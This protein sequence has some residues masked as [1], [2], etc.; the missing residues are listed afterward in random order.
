MD[1]P[2]GPVS[3]KKRLITLAWDKYSREKTLHIARRVLPIVLAVVVTLGMVLVGTVLGIGIAIYPHL[4]SV[5]AL[6]NTPNEATRIFAAD[7]EVVASLY[8]ENRVSIPLSQVPRGLQRAVIDTEDADFYR[9]RGISVRG[10]LRA[11]FRNLVE[12]SYAE[13]GSTIT[14]QLARNLFLTGEKSIARKIAEMM[15]AIQI[16]RRLTK[17]EILER[18]LN[19]VYFGQGAYGVETA[20]EV[21]FGKP[22]HEL[23]LSESAMLAGLIRAPTAYSPYEH[24]IRARARR[25]EVLERMVAVRDISPKERDAALR[26]P[27]HLAEKGNAGLIGIRA[28]YFVSYL[29]PTLVARY[30]EDVLYKAGLR[31]YTTLDLKLQEQADVAIRQGID[32]ALRGHLEAHQG[33]LVV[34]DPRTG[35]VRA[36]V[37]GYDFRTSQFNRAW[38]AHRQPGSAFK[39]FTYTVAMMQGIPPT[40]QL[41]DAP[42]DVTEPDGTVWAPEN[43]DKKWHGVVS[44]R[45]A[46]E[47][48]INV[49]SIRLEQEVGPQA[50]VDLAHHMGIQSTLQPNLSL[51]LGTADV[52]LL[53]MTSAYG[54]FASGGVRAEPLAILK[55]TDRNGKVLEEHVPQRTVVLNP[56][57]SYMMIDLLKGVIQRGTGVAA[58]IKIPEAG[59]TGTAD[60]FRNAWFIGFT[61]YMVTGVWV[62]N[63]DDSPMNHVPGGSVPANIWASFMKVA[64]ADQPK[65]DWPRPDGIVEQTVCGSTGLLAGPGCTDPHQEIFVKGTEPESYA[66]PGSLTGTPGGPPAVQGD[67][68]AAGGKPPAAPASTADGGAFSLTLTSPTQGSQVTPPFL[69]QGVTRPSVT[70]HVTV[71]SESGI[72]RVQ[73]ADAYLRSDQSG[74]FSYTVNPW[75]KPSGGTLNI[76][77]EAASGTESATTSTTV[78]IH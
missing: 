3:S 66:A 52:T 21:Y 14:Q 69:V 72:L 28:P 35:Y 19:Q 64:T 4:P 51:T 74:A 34:L 6:Y 1:T 29:L 20:A 44:V 76:T 50:I 65:D 53:E 41:V 15:L 56:Q 43:Y 13:G 7:G 46:L 23:T 48:S 5:D 58:N 22:A 71:L 26:G 60:D 47:N 62:G 75:L 77:V 40:R 54:V 61:P 16:E 73:V 12:G 39:P 8:Q 25:A 55:V 33:A 27:L 36:M 59:K 67:P 38:Q 30:G 2:P 31:I 78:Q 32:A 70:V 42:F 17:D 9:N 63:D 10:I 57:V 45:Y 18:Y 49:A 11:S 68:G 37:G 24:P